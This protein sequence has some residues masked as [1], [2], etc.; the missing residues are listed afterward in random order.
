MN[1]DTSMEASGPVPQTLSMEDL[2]AAF[3]ALQT[4][5]GRLG[6]ENQR[7][8]AEVHQLR[9]GT[10][11]KVRKSYI[12]P[13]KFT[14][15]PPEQDPR[16]SPDPQ[17]SPVQ[18]TVNTPNPVPLAMP[19]RF[20]GDSSKY[21]VFMNQC[22]LQFLC[23]A[24]SFPDDSAKV[25][26]IISYLV[27]NAAEW[28]VPLVRNNDPLLYDLDL[29]KEKM[30]SLFAKHAYMQAS[31]TELLNLRQGSKDLLSY[32]TQF[33]RLVAETH[34]PEDKRTSLFYR[35]LGE[36]LKDLLSQIVDP[37][38]DCASFI[39]L[40]VKLDHRLHERKGERP[41]S[42]GPK[43]VFHRTEKPITRDA[44]E[45]MQIGGIRGPLSSEEKEKRRK[46]NLCLYC[47]KGGHFAR[48][49]PVR[50]KNPRQSVSSLTSSENSKA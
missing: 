3:V 9:T 40:V 15:S 49:C 45:P 24:A 39:D 47:G 31:D 46:L 11:P 4:E 5:V 2:M 10:I 33:N 16:A 29:F 34:W 1:S 41:R 37:P 50:P 17:A 23:K 48:E 38:E 20:T 28:A 21:E 32:I 42:V 35:G 19:E 30:R 43:M 36:E 18:V 7:L 44:P 25:A 12:Q 8:V 26:F 6:T 22:Q 13:A 14:L 27:G